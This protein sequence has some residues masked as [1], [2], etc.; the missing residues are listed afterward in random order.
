MTVPDSG[1][2]I[3]IS[4]DR[5][6]TDTIKASTQDRNVL[7]QQEIRDLFNKSAFVSN[8]ASSLIRAIEKQAAIF[9]IP[10]HPEAAEVRAAVARKSTDSPSG[11][12]I[13]FDLFKDAIRYSYLTKQGVT[14]M[15]LREGVG[16]PDSV[17][18]KKVLFLRA[19]LMY[20]EVSSGMTDADI[21]MLISQFFILYLANKILGPFEGLV[22]TE[23]LLALD[24][25][26]T[27]KALDTVAIQV[28]ESIVFQLIIFGVNTALLESWLDNAA[29]INLPKGMTGKS[30]IEAAKARE[31]KPIH[32]MAQSYVG[33]DDYQ[34][35]LDYAFEYIG[36][37]PNP[38]YDMW[39]GYVD[40][41]EIRF[42]AQNLWTYAP[43]Y[44]SAH[45]FDQVKTGGRARDRRRTSRFEE[46]EEH[47]GFDLD[48]SNALGASLTGMN[49]DYADQENQFL[50]RASRALDKIAQV[51]GSE[52]SLDALCCLAR[53]LVNI[54][55]KKLAILKAI[56]QVMLSS[57]ADFYFLDLQLMLSKIRELSA[58]ECLARFMVTAVQ[59]FFDKLAREFLGLLGD[60]IVVLLCCPLIKDLVEAFLRLLVDVENRLIELIENFAKAIDFKLGGVSKRF[61]FI[62]DQRYVHQMMKVI[63]AVLN[64][65]NALEVC[66]EA[67][68][69][70]L[71]RQRLDDHITSSQKL[72]AV[73]IPQEEADRYFSTAEAQEGNNKR[74]IPGLGQKVSFEAELVAE[75]FKTKADEMT[76]L[77]PGAL[78]II[79]GVP[80]AA[81]KASKE[82]LNAFLAE[83]GVL[84]VDRPS[85]QTAKESEKLP[86]LG[87]CYRLFTDLQAKQAVSG[88]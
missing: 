25:I 54:P 4:R 69:D 38:G 35:I 64:M 84:R 80:G 70:E 71:I 1:Y 45:A 2:I 6:L 60:D 22:H 85:G 11:E 46:P 63:D 19:R 21:G 30:L 42:Q 82:S 59:K 34:R 28:I 41:F 68:T 83:L 40:S 73:V 51:L 24:A 9:S 26:G 86:G 77:G 65:L 20:P 61:S 57:A 55:K 17:L 56:L 50:D 62:N 14:E 37:H 66:G 43:L 36:R 79:S 32:K 10:V 72:P 87:L 44:S 48:I 88:L 67:Q 29:E 47:G 81:A 76:A 53:F 58:F 33:L 49:L 5:V 15:I 18:T 27:Q 3:D 13:S 39:L 8:K 12:Q 7:S 23:I 52:F 78:D 16:D 31:L 74:I 75:E